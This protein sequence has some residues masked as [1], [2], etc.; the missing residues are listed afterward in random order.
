MD[1]KQKDTIKEGGS[2]DDII[3]NN[4][5]DGNI[6]DGIN[7][8]EEGS[9]NIVGDNGENCGDGGSK[10]Q[11]R[12]TTDEWMKQKDTIKE[13]GS[14][15][16][17]IKNNT[18]DGNISDGINDNEKGSKNIVGDYGES[19]GDGGSKQQCSG[20]SRQDE[21]LSV[22]GY[23]SPGEVTNISNQDDASIIQTDSVRKVDD[24]KN[25][26][27]TKPPWGANVL[28]GT[29]PKGPWSN[30]A[31]GTNSECRIFFI[32]KHGIIY[33]SYEEANK[34]RKKISNDWFRNGKQGERIKDAHEKG[35]KGN[36]KEMEI[37]GTCK[38]GVRGQL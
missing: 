8:N 21:D 2:I 33:K 26:P 5:R 14:I 22:Q 3:K 15:D 36:V 19:C 20:E 11:L 23:V 10:Q 17:I 30:V 7:D 9:K 31:P 34:M 25:P 32:S 4:T 37:I 16:D 35:T 13:G 6:S 29:C 12:R 38:K 1:A 18:R 28:K 24:G 27:D